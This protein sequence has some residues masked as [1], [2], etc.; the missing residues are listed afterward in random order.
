MADFFRKHIG[1]WGY[2]EGGSE[3]CKCNDIQKFVSLET[4]ACP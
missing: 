1:A 4:I 3:V 2:K